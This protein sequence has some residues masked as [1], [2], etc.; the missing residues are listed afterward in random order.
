MA[1]APVT[2]NPGTTYAV[3]IRITSGTTLHP[4]GSTPRQTLGSSA[5]GFTPMD[6]TANHIRSANVNPRV[7]TALITITG[8]HYMVNLVYTV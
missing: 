3:V 5:L 8:A 7:G 6:T 1:S 4:A 2:M